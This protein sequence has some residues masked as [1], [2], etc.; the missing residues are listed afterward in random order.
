MTEN[1]FRKLA[2]SFPEAEEKSH[3]GHPDFRV[4]GK[5]FATLGHR[6][7]RAVVMLEPELQ[8]A[9]MHAAPDAF[10]PAS[11]A[12][13][14]GGATSI[15][16]KRCTKTIAKDALAAAWRRRAPKRLLKTLDGE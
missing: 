15:E 5:I 16:L 3:M 8:E 7:G 12:W 1:D 9:F 10:E 2:L 4:G 11:G 6:A 13:G 14:R